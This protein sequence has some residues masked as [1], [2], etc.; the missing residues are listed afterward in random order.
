MTCRV[1]SGLSCTRQ[2]LGWSRLAEVPLQGP[3]SAVALVLCNSEWGESS[4]LCRNAFSSS[5]KW[6]GI[7]ASGIG[8]ARSCAWPTRGPASGIWHLAS[9]ILGTGRESLLQRRHY[10]S[11]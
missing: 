4:F 3:N 9:G 2:A 11:M 8:S 1:R 10:D 6:G 5:K 7:T